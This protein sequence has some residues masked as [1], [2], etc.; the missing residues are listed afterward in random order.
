MLMQKGADVNACDAEKR[1]PLHVATLVKSVECVKAL[2]GYP[3][4]KIDV[5]DAEVLNFSANEF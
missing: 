2:L 3:E 4:L 1:T 5:Q